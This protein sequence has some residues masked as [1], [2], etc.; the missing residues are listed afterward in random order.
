MKMGAQDIKETYSYY[1]K[2][3]ASR[4]PSLAY[5]HAVES[6]IAGNVTIEADASESLDWIHDLWAPR[7]FFVA[8]GFTEEN[9]AAETA[10]LSNTAVVYGRYFISNPDLVERLREGIPFRKYN[11]DTFYLLG[12]DQPK[13]YI[14]Y[15]NATE[16]EKREA[17]AGKA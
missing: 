4:F 16:E 13:G 5:L 14:D 7:P 12:P 10:R 8:G 2:E 6:R 11:R 1:V 15:E 9:A 17:K 3:L